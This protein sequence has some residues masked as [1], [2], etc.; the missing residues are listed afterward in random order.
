[1][2]MIFPPNP[3]VPGLADGD[4]FPVFTGI[5]DGVDQVAP[6]RWRLRLRTDDG[7]LRSTAGKTGAIPRVPLSRYF[8][9]LDASGSSFYAP[10]IYGVHNSAG[11]SGQGF[12]PCHL[13]DSST[14]KYV[15]QLGRA[16]AVTAVYE[17]G[18]LLASGLYTVAYETVKG[19]LFTVLNFTSAHA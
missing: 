11:S 6:M 2:R 5:L 13:V 17:D 16:N 4:S 9:G 8:D 18:A 1:I 14:Y 12:V 15:V 3:D 19:A 10:V 7:P